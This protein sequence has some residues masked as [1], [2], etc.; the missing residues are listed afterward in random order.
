VRYH[1]PMKRLPPTLLCLAVLLAL[2]CSSSDEGPTDP[3]TTNRRLVIN[4]AIESAN[5]IGTLQEVQLLFDNQ[6]IARYAGAAAAAVS[7][8]GSVRDVVPGSH[9]VAVRIDRQVQSPILYRMGQANGPASSVVV[10]NASGT[11]LATLN[12]PR[13]T[14]LLATGDSQRYTIQVP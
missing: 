11:V 10:S 9:T 4:F 3:G 13:E 2:A 12:L 14:V 7:V 6:G 5:G 8:Q 1:R